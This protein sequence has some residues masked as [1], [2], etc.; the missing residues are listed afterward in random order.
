MQP[1]EIA[2]KLSEMLLSQKEERRQA[3]EQQKKSTSMALDYAISRLRQTI[4]GSYLLE[5]YPLCRTSPKS[6]P[7]A[8]AVLRKAGS[9]AM[10]DGKKVYVDEEIL[11]DMLVQDYP[12][13]QLP[14]GWQDVEDLWTKSTLVNSNKYSMRVGD[15]LDA[16]DATSE[17][18]DIILHELTHAANEHCKL[19]AT[20]EA[21]GASPE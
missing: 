15:D 14:R 6:Y 19:S 5:K 9:P 11:A 13:I 3:T 18:M 7:E 8:N 12:G 1:D 21:R 4:Y 2:E 17:I 16:S 20:A 10:T